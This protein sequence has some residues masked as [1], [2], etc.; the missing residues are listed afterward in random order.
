MEMK[1]IKCI[2][3]R[4]TG[5]EFP[6]NPHLLAYA[7]SDTAHFEIIYSEETVTVEDPGYT[8]DKLKAMSMKD[9][10][11]IAEAKEL[12]CDKRSKDGMIGAILK[13]GR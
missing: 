11:L 2:K 6:E 1:K 3:N 10:Q 13:A 8:M 5:M 7:K 4:L 9:L 12:V